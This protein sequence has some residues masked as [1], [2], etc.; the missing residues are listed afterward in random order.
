M[1]W[2]IFLVPSEKKS[3]LDDVLRDELIARQSQKVRDAGTYG[4]PSAQ[5]YVQVEGSNEA[6]QRAE[7]L[8]MELGTKLPSADAERLRARFREEDDAASAGMGLFFTE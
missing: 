7:T 6:V 3:N 5:L 4:G 2:T 8:L 1:A